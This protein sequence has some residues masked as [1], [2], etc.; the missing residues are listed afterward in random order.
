MKG[1]DQLFVC[2][3]TPFSRETVIGFQLPAATR[4]HLAVQD[5]NGRVLHTLQGEYSAGYSEL[6]L[7]A[8]ALPA[9]GVLFYTLTTPTHRATKR[10]VVCYRA[11][12]SC[13]PI[14]S[15]F[16]TRLA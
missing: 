7:P 14:L 6:S 2:H 11:A 8:E 15:E 1:F 3:K 10:M 9:S 4:V 16:A 13:I 5:P 12:I